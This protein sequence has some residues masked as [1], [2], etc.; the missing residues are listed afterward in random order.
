[1]LATRLRISG[2]TCGH[3]EMAIRKALETVAG[4]SRVVS[5]SKDQGEAV[6]EG[7][8]FAEALKSAVT[9]EGYHVEDIK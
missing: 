9:A 5:V 4:V 2:M 3:C 8:A 6:V 7:S 1:M